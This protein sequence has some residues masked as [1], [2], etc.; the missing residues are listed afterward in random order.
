M[1]AR[2]AVAPAVRATVARRAGFHTTRAQLA[3]PYHYPEGPLSNIPFNPRKRG[4]ALGYWSFC[5]VGFTLPFG[6]A[7]WQ[8]YHP[9]K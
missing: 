3:S 5:V 9:A 2:A 7:A 4:F 6:I 8:T 1:L